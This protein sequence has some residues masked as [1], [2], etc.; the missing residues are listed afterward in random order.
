MSQRY[1]TTF[2]MRPMYV[3]ENYNTASNLYIYTEITSII[4]TL[5]TQ[6]IYTLESTEIT[7]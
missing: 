7:K 4:Q 3:K 5:N 1:T 6:A 2:C